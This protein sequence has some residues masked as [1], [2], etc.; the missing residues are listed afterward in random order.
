MSFCPSDYDGDTYAR[1]ERD[2]RE[3]A[4]RR[5]DERDERTARSRAEEAAEDEADE[6]E[7]AAVSEAY[8]APDLVAIANRWA[9]SQRVRIIARQSAAKL[10]AYDALCEA[11]RRAA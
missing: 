4:A 3:D 2:F 7:F 5:E 10:E 8:D 1:D 11:N 6:R 9:F